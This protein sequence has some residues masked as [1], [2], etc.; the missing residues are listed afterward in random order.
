M[1]SLRIYLLV[2]VSKRMLEDEREHKEQKHPRAREKSWV[3]VGKAGPLWK[4]R[5]LGKIRRV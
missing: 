4:V 3:L 5:I 1:E 2:D